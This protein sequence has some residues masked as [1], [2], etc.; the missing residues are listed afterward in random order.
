ML[1]GGLANCCDAG[2]CHLNG[3]SSMVRK[4]K[5]I[6]RFVA[7]VQGR[8]IYVDLD[9]HKKTYSVALFDPEDGIVETY[10]CPSGE[11]ALAEQLA[12]LGCQIAHVVYESGP[13]GFALSRALERAGFAV[14]VIA[15]SRSPRGYAAAAKP[16]RI[17]A[18]KLATDFARGL[19][20]PIAIPT[21]EQ[22]S[23]RARVRRGKR[24]A[25][26]RGKIKQTIKGFLLAS[27]IQ[28]PASIQKWSKA[29]SDD[30]AALPIP[31]RHRM[32][33]AP[34]VREYLFLRSED[35]LLR[36]EIRTATM[37]MHPERFNRAEEVTSYLGLV[38]VVSQSGNS[39]ARAKLR[40]VGQKRLR[41]ILV[42]SAWQWT[43]RDAE[44][45]A[46]Y[47]HHFAK[48]GIGQKAIVAVART[49]AT[50]LWRMT[51]ETPPSPTEG[52]ARGV[53]SGLPTTKK[54]R[55]P[56]QPARTESGTW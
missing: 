41:G 36:A 35:K 39:K 31:P 5:R 30:L 23:Y 6:S 45:K 24:I 33:L 18:V 17:D 13:T 29:A 44:A 14:S 21:V 43:W 11:E 7:A 32:A 27:G 26:S 55:H 42:E 34:M 25:E 53:W 15:A 8:L 10:T 19:L 12:G 56:H 28:E 16:D 40:P 38:P 1:D 2:T 9:V 48:H 51:V 50:K 46:I 47:N 54:G 22:E 37:W 20:R 4:A 3:V 49:L 52:A